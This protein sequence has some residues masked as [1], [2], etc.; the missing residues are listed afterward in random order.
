M[1]SLGSDF[2]GFLC[3]DSAMETTHTGQR[4]ELTRIVGE[5][6]EQNTKVSV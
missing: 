4:M 2:R 6:L 1:I 3:Y 5:W